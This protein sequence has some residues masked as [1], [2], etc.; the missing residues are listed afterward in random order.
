FHTD[1]LYKDIYLC[2]HTSIKGNNEPSKTVDTLGSIVVK[3]LRDA[4]DAVFVSNTGKIVK[5]A[6][7]IINYAV[8]TLVTESDSQTVV[9]NTLN[10]VQ[11]E[12]GEMIGQTTVNVKNKTVSN[13]FLAS[14]SSSA[15]L[16]DF[17]SVMGNV[18][19]L[20][21]STIR[22]KSVLTSNLTGT[23][24]SLS[25]ETLKN[26]LPA[27]LPD[28][29]SLAADKDV[30]QL[31]TSHPQL[32]NEIVNIASVNLTSGMLI[33]KSDISDVIKN[34]SSL[35]QADKDRLIN[36][37]P[38]LPSFDQDIITSG[39]STLALVD[40]L[41]KEMEQSNPGSTVEVGSSKGLYLMVLVKDPIAK[42]HIP[43]Y[44]QDARVVSSVIPQGMY[45]LPEGRFLLVSN[46]IAGIVTPAP[47]DAV[48]TLLSADNLL[49]IDAIF[50]SDKKEIANINITN[51][52][53]LNIKFKDGSRFSGTFG[54]G[55]VKKGGFDAGT[56]SFELHGKDPASEAYS[57]LLRYSDGST[58]QIFP[59][60]S[61]L[62]QLIEVLDRLAPGSYK[63]DNQTGILTVLGMNFRPN[64][65][66]GVGST[67]D[68]AWFYAN[69]DSNNIAWE[70]I[71]YNADSVD[72]LKMWTPDGALVINQNIY[73]VTQ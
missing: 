53:V 54:Y 67:D 9:K 24:Q 11:V 63:I 70:I 36:G 23:M 5:S 17:T 38:E 15:T 69:K 34:Y 51:A 41:R 56:S 14:S 31:L 47:L 48:D 26:V 40:L 57:V 42:Q 3:G 46:G 28:N 20:T 27:F 13:S 64:Y 61:A 65:L 43:F 8:D 73:T 29:T 25:R 16:Q 71:D 66:I 7:N 12:L 52:G 50:G 32:L 10:Q 22:A 4:T 55:A 62:E 59:S 44:I 18:S 30:Q 2:R 35:S 33:T 72:D 37:L 19:T 45:E 49:K 6:G 58:Q 39:G 1:H 68:K 60:V 21:T